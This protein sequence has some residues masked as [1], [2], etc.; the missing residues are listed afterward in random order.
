MWVDRFVDALEFVHESIVDGGSACGVD[1]E[2]VVHEVLAAFE[3]F[4]GD[5]GWLGSVHFGKDGDTNLFA[6][7]F[8][9]FDCGGALDVASREHGL[10]ALIKEPFCELGGG[11]GFS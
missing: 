8:E 9:L 10:F 11:G 2:N 4:F 5:D 7:N 3:G 6:E 1:D